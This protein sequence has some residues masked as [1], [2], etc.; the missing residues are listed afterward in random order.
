MPRLKRNKESAFESP[1]KPTRRVRGKMSM[2]DVE[3]K[4]FE[5]L[6]DS[7]CSGGGGGA[8][9]S[10]G[11]GDV[12]RSVPDSDSEAEPRMDVEDDW[13]ADSDCGD[14][15]DDIMEE[16]VRK[17]VGSL[18][19]ERHDRLQRNWHLLQEVQ[20][21]RGR[22]FERGSGC[23]GSGMDGHGQNKVVDLCNQLF[24]C[25]VHISTRFE[26]D[27]DLKKRRWL[28]QFSKPSRLFSDVTSLKHN[29]KLKDEISGKQVKFDGNGILSYAFGFSCR[30]FSTEN[31][32][33]HDIV[34]SCLE[35]ETGSSGVTWAGN[36]KYVI[37][38][39]PAWLF[40]ENVPRLA[41]TP[42]MAF[43]LSE[44]KRAGYEVTWSLR[45]A[46][47]YYLPQARKRLWLHARLRLLCTPGWGEEFQAVMDEMMHP[48]P[49]PLNRFL[50][51]SRSAHRQRVESANQTAKATKKKSCRQKWKADH[52]VDRC[53]SKLETQS[54]MPE[55]LREI[56]LHS[57]FADR[58]MDFL[59][60]LHQKGVD[61]KELAQQKPTLELKHSCGRIKAFTD[62]E[63]NSMSTILPGS[64]T[65]QAMFDK[66]CLCLFFLSKL[67]LSRFMKIRILLLRTRPPRILT[68]PEALHVQ[69]IGLKHSLSATGLTDRDFYKLA[70]D[71]FACS[72]VAATFI[73]A[74]SCSI[75]SA[76]ELERILG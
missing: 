31:N 8:A 37:Q 20:Q 75:L 27:N 16:V 26:T 59:V 13:G 29:T 33:S 47:D 70:G 28:K 64:R 21:H 30:D 60:M 52:W 63:T 35:E 10:D 2:K 67:D 51:S 69:G 62:K 17:L 53:H 46:S 43:L 25:D 23:S 76:T 6:F 73:A 55:H 72:V 4:E 38:S 24:D 68:G 39:Q 11:D 66:Q 54:A 48:E 56:A 3:I 7:C 34:Q 15:D 22:E 45:T 1:S 36:F 49:L 57:S 58:E 65:R 41:S 50:L 19:P 5:A 14:M 18:S 61:L 32:T 42:N 12:G 74:L 9:D 71:A 40:V 44:L